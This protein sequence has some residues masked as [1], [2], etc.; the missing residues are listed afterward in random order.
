MRVIGFFNRK[1]KRSITKRFV[2]SSQIIKVYDG[3]LSKARS[4]ENNF[5]N[6]HIIDQSFSPIK[7]LKV[8]LPEVQTTGCREDSVN[9]ERMATPIPVGSATLQRHFLLGGIFRLIEWELSNNVRLSLARSGRIYKKWYGR[10]T[11]I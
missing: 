3:G 2:P 7:H 6:V 9:G 11:S 8:K 4:T 5:K 1:C 10:P